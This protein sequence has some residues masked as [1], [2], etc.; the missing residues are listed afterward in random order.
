M[1]SAFNIEEIDFS[2]S[3]RIVNSVLIGYYF[4]R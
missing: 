2:V 4:F 3:E 1:L